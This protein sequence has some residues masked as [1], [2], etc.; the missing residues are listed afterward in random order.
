[1]EKLNIH[2]YYLGYNEDVKCVI[3][4]MADKINELIKEI[5]DIRDDIT[6]HL[7]RTEDD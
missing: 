7:R 3:E 1:M 5:N 6:D 4:K 2:Q